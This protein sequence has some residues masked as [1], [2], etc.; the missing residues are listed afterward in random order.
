MKFLV[1]SSMFDYSGMILRNDSMYL[2]IVG[3]IF[4][5]LYCVIHR[6]MSTLGDDDSNLW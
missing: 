5:L 1:F 2:Q 4:V 3:Y 6:E